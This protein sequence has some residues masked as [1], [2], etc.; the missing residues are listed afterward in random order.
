MLC[1]S[2]RISQYSTGSGLCVYIS[3]CV[4]HQV[5]PASL[6]SELMTHECVADVAVIGIPDA[7]AGELPRAYVV[8]KP[9]THTT[10]ALLLSYIAGP[11]FV[12]ICM[13]PMILISL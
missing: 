1:I 3:A 6:E 7:Y 10:E 13:N 11:S 8:L 5:A 4:C 12:I 9:N 2:V